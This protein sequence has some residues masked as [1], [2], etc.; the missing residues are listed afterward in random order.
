MS[1]ENASRTADGWQAVHLDDVPS[2]RSESGDEGDWKPLRHDLGISA[3]GFNAWSGAEPGAQVIE[4]HDE[5]PD[6]EDPRSHQEVYVVIAGRAEFTIDGT[7][8]EA[9]AGTV[10]AVRDGA[11]RREASALEAG[12][13][14]LTVGA[15]PGEA[16]STSP[17]ERR[18]LERHGRW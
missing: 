15:A 1:P 18:A 13:T 3:F 2:I 9:P 16:F 14:I 5:A 7:T 12:T 11:L 17:W 4:P 6:D 8:F 10:V